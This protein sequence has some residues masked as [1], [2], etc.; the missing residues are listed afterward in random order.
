MSKW[1]PGTESSLLEVTVN[2]L[3]RTQTDFLNLIGSQGGQL[4]VPLFL[5]GGFCGGGVAFI[6][7]KMVTYW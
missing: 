3:E 2:E 6:F 7:F 5:W 4:E 1:I